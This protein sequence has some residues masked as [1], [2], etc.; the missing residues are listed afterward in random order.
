[1]PQSDIVESGLSKTDLTGFTKNNL[2]NEIVG[3]ISTELTS[4]GAL[5]CDS[6]SDSTPTPHFSAS[7]R[8][9]INSRNITSITNI[10][11]KT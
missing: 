1:M 10:A 9:I 4:S 8:S 5:S 2:S 11:P 6:V 3:F 7:F